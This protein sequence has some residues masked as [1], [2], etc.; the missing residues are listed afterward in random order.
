MSPLSS[1]GGTSTRLFRRA[2]RGDASAFGR[3]LVRCLPDLRRWAHGRLPYWA[4][5]SAETSDLI[6]DALVHTLRRADVFDLRGRRA[7]AAYL[8]SAVRNRVCDEHRRIGRRGTAEA[9][10]RTIVDARPSPL[11]QAMATDARARYH[12][13]LA[14]LSPTDRDLIVA[15]VE[16]DY[17]HD[18][19]AC[20]TGRSRNAA[21]MALQRAIERLA[22]QMLRDG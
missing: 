2:R 18:Q 6:Q 16:L 10:A 12:A 7:L 17:S 19:L 4:R 3:L 20:M 9:V 8:R 5:T 22:R 1:A 21:R 11:D 15:H 14:R 13:A